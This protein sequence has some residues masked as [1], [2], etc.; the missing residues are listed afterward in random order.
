M[1]AFLSV[2]QRLLSV[3]DSIVSVGAISIRHLEIFIRRW[4]C[5]FRRSEIPIRRGCLA[6]RHRYFFPS[7]EGFYPSMTYLA[8]IQTA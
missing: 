3:D 6:F 5:S 7:P 1:T 8:K 2:A 4:R